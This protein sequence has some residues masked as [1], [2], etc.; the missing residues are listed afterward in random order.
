ME[1]FKGELVGDKV[2]LFDKEEANRLYKLGFFGKFVGY[3]KVKDLELRDYLELSLLES[4]YLMD[5]GLLKVYHMGR[6]VTRE[7]LL[8]IARNKYEHFDDMYIVYRDLRKK[9]YVVKSGLKFGSTF[10]VYEHG[11]GIDHAPFLVHVMP[12]NEAIDP[13]EIV[14]AGRLSH[15]VRK[16]FILATVNPNNEIEYYSFSWFG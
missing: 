8:N 2:I 7:E 10:A 5:E 12:Y 4:L 1:K 6:I 14:R 15:S 11:P 16:K 3:R 9:G 13:I